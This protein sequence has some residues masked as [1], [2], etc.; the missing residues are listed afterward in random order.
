MPDVK[1]TIE[2]I[3]AGVDNVSGTLKTIGGNAE[4]FG[5]S[6]GDIGAPFADAAGY[7]AALNTAIA[8]IAI[9]G[10]KMSSDIET[11]SLKMQA[12]LGLPVEEVERF[13][14]IAKEVYTTGYADDLASAFEAVTLA[15][16]KFGDDASV[17]IGKVTEQALKLQ[18]V[19]GVEYEQSLSAIST[20]TK[21]FGIDS[22]TAF[23]FVAKGFQDGLDGSGDFLESI[24]EYSV[25]FANGGADAGQFFSVLET[26]FQ[27][28][29]LGVDKAADAFGEFRK[30]ILDDSKT[31]KDALSLIGLDNATLTANIDSGKTTIIE[32]FNL[33]IKK[34]NETDKESIKMQAGVGL[35]GTQFE[36]LG[37]KAALSISTATTSIKDFVKATETVK[38]EDFSKRIESA[39]RTVAISF[40]DLTIWDTAKKRIASLFADI[41]EDI[42]GAF[43]GADFSGLVDAADE[44]WNQ[45]G[46]IFAREDFDLTT[47]E[48]LKNAIQTIIDSIESV[49]T[50]TGGMVD[51][52]SPA[53]TAISNMVKWFNDLDE[54]SK[55]LV[56]NVIAIGTQLAV[57]G[58]IVSTGGALISGIGS[59]VALIT[60]PVGLVVGLGA[61]GV[62][63]DTAIKSLLG[64]TKAEEDSAAKIKEMNEVLASLELPDEISIPISAALD[65]GDFIKAGELID[66]IPDEA[67][68]TVSADTPSEE[69]LEY[70]SLFEEIP[71]DIS[72]KIT[73]AI[74]RGDFDEVKN[75]I[76]GLIADPVVVEIKADTS[77]AKQAFSELAFW[78]ESGGWQTIKIPIEA[79]IDTSKAEKSAEELAKNL[80]PLK[81][82]EILTKLDIKEVDQNI[83]QIKANAENLQTAVEWTAKIE[84]AEFESD[85]RKVES[86]FDSVNVGIKSTG[87]LI[88]VA[89]G[90]MGQGEGFIEKWA[91]QDVLR[92]EQE[93]REQE[94]N[95]QKSLVEQQTKYLEL[96]NKAFEETGGEMEIKI[97][98][99]GLEP[100]LELVMWEIIQKVQA[101]ASES[102]AEFLLGIPT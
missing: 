16:K 6:I 97:D 11:A 63:A 4:A 83:A 14:K 7:V 10:I 90:A 32:A 58:G 92:Q 69:I 87:D 55:S 76:A 31:T 40:G 13:E 8:G 21:N 24:G 46:D 15:Q 20:L 68:T 43:E 39:W 44:I 33:V 60:G 18:E 84:I 45:I 27:E 89:L 35:L 30:R 54:G 2:I 67:L 66:A 72:T 73:A 51:A 85:M 48:G 61:I 93:F 53:I 77:E 47:L 81:T 95:L 49:V 59:L 102:A 56:G 98:S 17:D 70:T 82:L 57:L 26:G 100:S 25:Q 1:K 37:T 62:A 19:F 52:F 75:I 91:A 50:V 65:A 78:T 36:E 96:K 34:L 28:G 29:W 74:E 64:I 79:E 86:A 94:F 5:D 71:P 12:S 88:G 23:G 80:D 101:R 3:F 38:I 41:A 42:P 9:A 99:T 22:E